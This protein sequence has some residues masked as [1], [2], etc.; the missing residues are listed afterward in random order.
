MTWRSC[1]TIAWI[2]TEILIEWDF[3]ASDPTPAR[4]SYHRSQGNQLHIVL[5]ECENIFEFACALL[6]AEGLLMKYLGYYLSALHILQRGSHLCGWVTLTSAR[7]F[8]V[9]PAS[10]WGLYQTQRPGHSIHNDPEIWDSHTSKWRILHFS[11]SLLI[12]LEVKDICE[13]VKGHFCHNLLLNRR[14]KSTD[15]RYL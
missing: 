13:S 15:K 4:F 8:C 2:G 9:W 10:H 12:L 6:W 3:H 1:S 14:R 5:K 7:H 11:R